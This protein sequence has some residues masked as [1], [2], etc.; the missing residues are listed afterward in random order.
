MIK[1][2]SFEIE[3]YISQHVVLFYSGNHHLLVIN[4]YTFLQSN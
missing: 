1:Y 2:V 4:M 3:M